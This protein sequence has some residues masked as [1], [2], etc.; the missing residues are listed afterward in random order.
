VKDHR[1][2]AALEMKREIALFVSQGKTDRQVIEYYRQKYGARVLVE[3]EGAQ[4]WVMNIIPWVILGMAAI[5][6]VFLLK[7]M[8]RPGPETVPVQ[9]AD[10]ADFD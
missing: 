1:S 4:F 6:L 3:P 8:L 5:I 10:L 9:G 2:E 7:R